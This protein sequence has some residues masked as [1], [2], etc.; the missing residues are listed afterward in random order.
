MSFSEGVFRNALAENIPVSMEPGTFTV[1]MQIGD[2]N[3]DGSTNISDV[4]LCLRIAI[5]LPVTIGGQVY[6]SPYPSWLLQC[7]DINLS[8]DLNISDVI[9][10]LRKSIGLP[11]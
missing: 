8:G 7:A 5:G 1:D 11:L 3:G 2:I 10:I 4:I 6:D 9:L